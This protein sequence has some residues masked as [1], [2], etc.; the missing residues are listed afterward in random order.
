MDLVNYGCLK[1]NVSLYT[2]H[3]NLLNINLHNATLS[4]SLIS[5]HPREWMCSV[6][7]SLLVLTYSPYITRFD[8]QVIHHRVQSTR[9]HTS[10]CHHCNYCRYCNVGFVL[11]HIVT[12]Y[13]KSILSHTHINTKYLLS[14][15]CIVVAT[16]MILGRLE[17]TNTWPKTTDIYLCHTFEAPCGRGAQC[18]F[19]CT[20]LNVKTLDMLP[21]SITNKIYIQCCDYPSPHLGCCFSTST[22][23]VR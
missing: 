21:Q 3:P 4:L 2:I 22:K 20:H 14:V 16:C 15:M 8:I 9:L 5:R 19:W 6:W 11:F 12:C 1:L 23:E 13:T 18:W 17:C 10:R 7:I